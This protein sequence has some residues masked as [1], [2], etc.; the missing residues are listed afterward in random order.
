MSDPVTPDYVIARRELN[1]LFA[2]LGITATV[3]GARAE[4]FLRTIGKWEDHA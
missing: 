1:D 4:A 2:S 3:G